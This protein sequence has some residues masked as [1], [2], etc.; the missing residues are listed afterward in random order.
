MSDAFWLLAP[1]ALAFLGVL[2]AVVVDLHKAHEA[3]LDAAALRKHSFL[4]EDTEWGG[5]DEIR[6]P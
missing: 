2:W 4:D 6:Y 1:M 5:K 3:R